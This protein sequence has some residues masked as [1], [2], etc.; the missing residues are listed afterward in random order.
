M[1]TFE[2]L[3]DLL[4][5]FGLGEPP[6]HAS[7]DQSS[8]RTSPTF[9]TETSLEERVNRFFIAVA[10][11]E[12]AC[13]A[14]DTEDQHDDH[15]PVTN[16]YDPQSDIDDVSTKINTGCPCKRNCYLNFTVDRIQT[17][18]LSLREMSKNE[19][20]MLLMGTLKRV[21]DNSRCKNKE[22]TRQRYDYY[23]DGKKI[24][25]EAFSFIFD[26]KHKTL[27]N[28]LAHMKEHGTEPR[29][30]GHT[31]R[32]APNA[33]AQDVI[34]NAIQF[35]INY[36]SEVGLPQPAAPRG[37]SDEPPIYLPSSDTKLS[38][39]QQY[40][41]VCIENDKLYVGLTTFKDLW[42]TCVPHIK[43]SSPIEDVCRTCEDFRQEIKL[44]MSEDDKLSATGRYQSHILQARKE[45][46]VY[47]KCVERS[48]EMFRKRQEL[49]PSAG[50]NFS[51]DDIH[52]TFDFSQY[53]KLPHHSR[54]N[55]PTYFIQPVKVQ[56]FGFR[57][58]GCCQYNYLISE[59]EILGRDGQ[60]A[61]GPDSVISMLDHAFHSYGSGENDCSIHADNCFGQNKNRYV[62]AYFAWRIMVGKHRNITYMMQIPGHTRCLIDAGF[63]NI[64]KLYRRTDCDTPQHI[65]E[66]VGK[67]SVSNFPVTYGA[68]G[69]IWRA[70]KV[71]L[72]DRFKKV[73]NISKYHS[74]RFTIE[75]P[76]VVYMKENADDID[77]IRFIICKT[78]YLPM[79][80]TDI[81][82]VLP[83]GGLSKERQEYLFRHVRPLVRQPFQDILCPIPTQTE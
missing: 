18:I 30:H 80:V 21:G 11:T 25:Q 83:P 16:E 9:A 70:W 6:T 56:I 27:R 32:R 68:D 76:G 72:S 74:F 20:E 69:W 3:D 53:V 38:I 40:K 44:A 26:T 63:G 5:V 22:R 42:S 54:E 33:F 57:V 61:H 29:V 46:D 4:S 8:G 60:L 73:P 51:M 31:G 64:K 34:R 19:K 55:G 58:D 1:D 36:A 7:Q 17:H 24:C 48:A 50:D 79:D 82:D 67:S 41:E 37:R 49:D 59:N 45:R 14:D 71:F 75:Q 39:H 62:L 2:E 10:V 47:K 35:L 43:I 78:H 66:V 15:V 13:Q 77:E 12:E 81:P 65:A 28:I 23:F 52:Y